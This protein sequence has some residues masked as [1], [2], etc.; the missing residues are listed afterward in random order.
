MIGEKKKTDEW[1]TWTRL[2]GASF[3][4]KFQ[5]SDTGA[6]EEA[7]AVGTWKVNHS[8]VSM[9][10][11]HRLAVSIETLSSSTSP[12]TH[13][14]THTALHGIARPQGPASRTA[15][16]PAIAASPPLSSSSSSSPSAS[17]FSRFIS[18][19]SYHANPRGCPSP[20]SLEH[21]IILLLPRLF[22]LLLLPPYAIS[23]LPHTSTTSMTQ[24]VS[25][26]TIL[27][28]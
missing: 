19:D 26:Q 7:R 13:T 28:G 5:S 25:P 23:C 9:H 1:L 17:S 24:L 12:H 15:K 20:N 3:H 14:H 11:E 16:A 21:G 8:L 4:A 27:R 6:A 10:D 22:P 18:L 2:A